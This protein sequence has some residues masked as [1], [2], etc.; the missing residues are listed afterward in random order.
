MSS[1][2]KVLR[3]RIVLLDDEGMTVSAIA[4]VLGIV[5]NTV[6]KWVRRWKESPELSVAE[7][8]KDLPRSG[9]PDKFTAEQI[10]K[11][12][13][14]CCENPSEYGRPITHWT[15]RELVAELIEQ[16]IVESISVSEVGRILRENDV[17]PHRN[18][19]WLN[20]K[21]DEFRDERITNIC[22]VYANAA[23]PASTI[24]SG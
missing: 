20:A 24:L 12:I 18:R 10:C 1:Q 9:C 13:A 16:K 4:S 15:Q 17:Q 11:I 19:Y 2:A 14:T 8:L 3:A 5:K 6:I 21:P 23:C 22:S 7:R